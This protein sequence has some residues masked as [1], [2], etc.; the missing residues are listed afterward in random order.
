MFSGLVRN[1]TVPQGATSE[2]LCDYGCLCESYK[3]PVHGVDV[4]C[5]FLDGQMIPKDPITLLLV[6]AAFPICLPEDIP[7]TC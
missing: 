2:K 3:A 7:T 5:V 1:M 4:A 6:P